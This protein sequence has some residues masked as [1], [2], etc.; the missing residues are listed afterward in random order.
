MRLLRLSLR[1]SFALVLVGGP[2]LGCAGDPG[3]G[4]LAPPAIPDEEHGPITDADIDGDGIAND[5]D[6]CPSVANA[7]QRR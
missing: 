1:A 3:E 2:L 7:D 6:N 4:P 5:N